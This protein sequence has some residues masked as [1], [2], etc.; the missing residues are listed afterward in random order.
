M[1]QR[2]D[3]LK[4]VGHV[5]D[6]RRPHVRVLLT[7]NEGRIERE[8]T[9]PR[10]RG[11]HTHAIGVRVRQQVEDPGAL[12]GQVL[13][14]DAAVLLTQVDAHDVNDLVGQVRGHFLLG[15]PQDKGRNVGRQ[16]RE[17]VRVAPLNGAAHLLCEGIPRGQQPRARQGQEGPQVTQRVLDRRATD[18]QAPGGIHVAQRPVGGRAG[19]LHGLRLVDNDAG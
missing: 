18:R 16:A 15:T 17:H 2:H 8:L 10:D 19:I 11:Q 1:P 3:L 7:L 9:Q 6:L 5:L 14:V 4:P 13:V 12:A